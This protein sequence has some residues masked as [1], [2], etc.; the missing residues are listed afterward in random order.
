MA[1]ACCASIDWSSLMAS[2]SSAFSCKIISIGISSS[3]SA[4]ESG[5]GGS[6]GNAARRRLATALIAPL[7]PTP[8][9]AA[10]LAGLA[11]AL[12]GLLLFGSDAAGLRGRP[13]FLAGTALLLLLFLLLLLL[14][15]LL[16]LLA[17]GRSAAS[18]GGGGGVA[19]RNELT[20]MTASGGNMRIE[21]RMGWLD[22]VNSPSSSPESI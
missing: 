19:A 8:E 12:A 11:A 15:M 17:A 10:A 14:L 22:S 5:G 2:M 7:K 21:P 16:L 3:S 1:T 20:L 13:G 18:S 6:S 9:P 4:S